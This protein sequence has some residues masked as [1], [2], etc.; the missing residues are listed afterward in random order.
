VVQIFHRDQTT[1]TRWARLDLIAQILAGM[2]GCPQADAER[3]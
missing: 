3:H 2:L 1:S